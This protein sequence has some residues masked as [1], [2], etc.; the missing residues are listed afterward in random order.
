[1]VPN[2]KPATPI[3]N[4]TPGTTCTFQQRGRRN[5]QRH[6]RKDPRQ[7]KYWIATA[8][9]QMRAALGIEK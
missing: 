8:L 5:L 4:L 7:I 3:N 6:F 1:V 2:T 9:K